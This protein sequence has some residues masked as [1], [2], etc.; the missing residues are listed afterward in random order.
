MTEP[1]KLTVAELC[2]VLMKIPGNVVVHVT[3]RQTDDRE[4]VGVDYDKD[5]KIVRIG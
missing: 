2:L 5:E 1:K 4:Y 3:E